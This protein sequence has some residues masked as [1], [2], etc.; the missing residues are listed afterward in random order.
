M[1]FP[2]FALHAGGLSDGV[3]IE[4]RK[5]DL[6]PPSGLSQIEALAVEGSNSVVGEG[7]GLSLQK[8][9]AVDVEHGAYGIAACSRNPKMRDWLQKWE[10]WRG[11]R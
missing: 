2:A 1:N 6:D 7:D 9:A 4:R 11:G 3:G 10:M 5:I 8:G